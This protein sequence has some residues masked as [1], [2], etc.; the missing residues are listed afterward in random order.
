MSRP[1]VFI[2]S[3]VTPAES[4]S[5]VDLADVKTLLGIATTASDAFLDLVIPQ[6]STTAQSWCNNP[7]VVETIQDQWFPGSEGWPRVV[8]DAYAPLQLKR[9]PLVEIVSVVETIAG[10]ATTLTL[11]TDFLADMNLGQL[12]RLN[13][14][15]PPPA[16]IS[17]RPCDW[18]PDP[19]VVQYQAGY[20]DIPGDVFAAVVHLVKLEY[21]SQTRDPL[22]RSQS[23]PNVYEA[24]YVMGTGPGGPGDLDAYAASKLERYR[25]P[26]IA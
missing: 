14:Y 1:G 22:I 21:Y 3:V 10:V 6:A 8:R 2:S 12:T 26:V 15:D 17:P 4:Y 18:R 23:S 5:L 11:N 7:F 25:V 19:V 20:A 24:S 13:T 9:W 16:G